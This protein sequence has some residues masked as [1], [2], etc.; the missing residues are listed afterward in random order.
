[1]TKFSYSHDINEFDNLTDELSRGAIAREIAKEIRQDRSR[2]IGVYGWWGSGKTYLLSQ[3]IGQLLDSNKGSEMEVIV[4]VF[5]AWK[6]EM[7]G[8]LAPGIIRSFIDIE[9]SFGNASI[10]SDPETYKSI[11]KG[12]LELISIAGPLI[13]PAG[14]ASAVAS[15]LIKAGIRNVEEYKEL[16]TDTGSQSHVDQVHREIREL[17]Q[18]ILESAKKKNPD[19]K[20]RLAMFIDDLDR[21]SPEN[22]V[23]MFEWLK[24]HL[25]VEKCTYVMALDHI[26]A[27]RAIVGQYKDYLRAEEGPGYGFRYLEKLVDNEY[28]LGLPVRTELM[29]IH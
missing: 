22:M 25:S 20:F 10:L 6:Y 28:E 9:K 4:G 29:A 18:A 17:A 13:G 11:G 21:C 16:L 2:V 5:E 27:A 14:Q 24:V 8:D 23:R 19:K 7:K 26:A 1:M 12:L 3:V 15:E